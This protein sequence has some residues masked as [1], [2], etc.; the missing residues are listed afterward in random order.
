MSRENDTAKTHLSRLGVN[1]VTVMR[2]EGYADAD[3]IP[4]RALVHYILGDY[5]P[6]EKGEEE[7]RR[8]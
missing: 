2:L 5:V 7:G 4:L 3:G 8:E 1:P 6:P